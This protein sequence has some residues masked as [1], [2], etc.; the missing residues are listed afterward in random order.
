MGT[1]LPRGKDVKTTLLH[2]A[3]SQGPSQARRPSASLLDQEAP[4]RVGTSEETSRC[5]RASQG[6]GIRLQ[7]KVPYGSG[8]VG[9]MKE[10]HFFVARRDFSTESGCERMVGECRRDGSWVRG[11]GCTVCPE[12]LQIP[13]LGRYG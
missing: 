9:R 8:W 12:D 6:L 2:I 7:S 10:M 3:K 4:A 13:Y 11:E 5:F 1:Y